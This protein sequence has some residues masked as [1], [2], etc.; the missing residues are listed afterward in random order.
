MDKD[1]YEHYLQA[2][3]LSAKGL[4]LGLSMVKQGASYLSVATAVED[5]IAREGAQLAFPVNLSVNDIAAHYT[6][7]HDDAL[8]FNAGDLVKVDV[9][10]RIGGYIGD[11]ARTLE[12]GTSNWRPLIEAS[13]A[14]LRAALS[15]MRA[16]ANTSDIGGQVQSAIEARGFH[17]I[18]NLTGHLLGEYQLHGRIA[19]PNI[20]EAGGNILETDQ[21]F[22]VEP[23]ATTGQGWVRDGGRS[24][25]FNVVQKKSLNEPMLS[26]LMEGLEVTKG[27]PFSQRFAHNIQE[28]P[29]KI[30]QRLVAKGCLHAYPILK[31]QSGGMVSQTE[32]TIIVTDSECIITTK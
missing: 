23:F 17:P 14:G 32:D 21:V 7:T 29:A 20:R 9:G 13:E 28:N 1:A 22:A 11:T 2:G 25:I 19:I 4:R 16:G 6:P 18:R 8:V 26:R 30:L 24:N 15:R 12:V 31:E 27:L 5:L 10:A 3:S